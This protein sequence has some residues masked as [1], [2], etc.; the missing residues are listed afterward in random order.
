MAHRDPEIRKLIGS[1][2]VNAYL[3]TISQE[4]IDSRMQ[5]ARAAQREVLIDQIDPDRELPA[6]ELERRLQA[7]VKA[8]MAELARK[9]VEAR[10]ARAEAERAARTDTEMSILAAAESLGG[11]A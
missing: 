7:K 5:H 8:R 6:D 10:K 3:S 1:Q 11:A 2:A 9:S 4:E